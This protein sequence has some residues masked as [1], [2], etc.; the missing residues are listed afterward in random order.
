[1]TLT[2]GSGA[3]LSHCVFDG[4]DYSNPDGDAQSLG[5]AILRGANAVV[6]MPE[7]GLWPGEEYCFS[8]ESRGVQASACFT[9]D[10]NA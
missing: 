1:M 3:P 6:V 2:T 9:V 4:T 5:R 10:D 8:V 7:S